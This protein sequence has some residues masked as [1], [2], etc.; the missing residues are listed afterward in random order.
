MRDESDDAIPPGRLRTMQIIAGALILGLAIFL[1]IVVYVVHVQNQGQ[2]I[3]QAQGP[4]IL[5]V[6]ALGMLA[7]LSVVSVAVPNAMLRQHIRRIACGQVTP[8][9]DQPAPTGDADQLLGLRQTTLIISLSLLQGPAFFCCIAYLLEGRIYALGGAL[10]AILLLGSRF[11]TE[12]S[13]RTWLRRQLDAADA[14]RQQIN[15]DTAP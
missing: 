11:P 1:A 15:P 7:A 9:V 13:L 6:L 5:S 8:T 14:A 12:A 3:G 2:P 10:L 4:P